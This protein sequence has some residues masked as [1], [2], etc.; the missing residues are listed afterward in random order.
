[1]QIS[2]KPL[3][4]FFGVC[5]LVHSILFTN[6]SVLAETLFPGD[7]GQSLLQKVA[8]EFRPSRTLSYKKARDLMYSN[9]DN[10]DGKVFGIYTNFQ[11][12]VDSDSSNPRQDAFLSGRGINAEH[13]WPQSKGATGQAKS[14]LHHLFPSKVAVNGDRGNNPFAEIMDSQ[15]RR[16]YRDSQKLQR[17]PRTNI[18]EYSEST[19]GFFEPREDKKGDVARAMFYFYTMYKSKADST[20]SRFFNRQRSTLCQWNELDPLSNEEVIR[21]HMISQS[22][23]NNENPFIIDSTLADRS[24]CN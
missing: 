9:L 1:M 7:S 18:D 2:L 19:S 15:T 12:S 22:L 11:V 23:Q 6:N 17:I 20:D 21:S 3:T 10:E 16:W 13:V 14:D 5:I 8:L 4:A 24:Y